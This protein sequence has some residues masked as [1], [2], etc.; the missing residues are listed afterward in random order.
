M[1]PT[2]TLIPTGLDVIRSPLRPVAVTVSVAV[3]AG[4][5]TV[6]TAVRV[7]PPALAVIVTSVDVVTA[8]VAIAKVVLVAPGAT[9]TL[10]GT[11]AAAVLLDSDTANPP[12]GAALVSVTLPCEVPPPVTLPGFSTRVFRLTGGGGADA[13][14]TV[15]VPARLVPL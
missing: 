7:T 5:A 10:A 1:L 8:L 15:S 2:A 6:K 11:V 4:G 13:A 9:D 3:C 12:A 14:V